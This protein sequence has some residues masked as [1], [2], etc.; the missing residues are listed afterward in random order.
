[1]STEG[2]P[3][4]TVPDCSS[5][6]QQGETSITFSG[7]Y[8]DGKSSRANE[9]TVC[10]DGKSLRICRDGAA[11]DI[12][13]PLEACIFNPAL[14]TTRRTITLPDGGLCETFDA[15]AVADL[16]RISGANKGMTFV[17][18]LEANW[19][20]V[21]ASIAGL[22]I[23]VWGFTA[24]AIPYLA[25]R[26]A[27]SIPLELTDSINDRTLDM[28]DDRFVAPSELGGERASEIH[29]LFA[30]ITREDTHYSYR[31]ELRKGANLG[32][33]AFALPA[34][35]IVMTDE[36]VEL[37][38]N[39]REIAGVIAHELAHVRMRHGLR[40]I[41]QNAGVFLVVSILAGDVA[42][43][44]STAA[45]FPTFII[46]SGYSRDF[47]RQADAAAAAYCISRG[48]TAGPY[49]DILKRLSEDSGPG[50]RLSWLSS[51][52]DIDERIH[53]IEELEHELPREE[54][55]S[56]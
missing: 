19:I 14:G 5:P 7:T 24:Y 2:N 44:T 27:Y 6:F 47:E 15:H 39:D 52:P 30:E 49:K 31:L 41:F 48:W 43:I 56:S 38:H 20:A 21:A 4:R 29:A 51:H 13:V 10:S 37:A 1:M 17:H 36:L 50:G 9:A 45:T 32:A 34:G 16:E 26:A 8:F 28:L 35:T 40:S 54:N 42:S 3:R 18:I 33:N 55:R 25:Q 12:T 22:V 46:E 23:F 53:L 11:P